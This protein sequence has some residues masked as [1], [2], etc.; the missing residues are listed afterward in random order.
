VLLNAVVIVLRE[1]LEASLIISVFLA[2]SQILNRSLKWMLLALVLG[3]ISGFIYA[4]TIST[5]SMAFGGIGQE[6]VNATINILIFMALVIFVTAVP[7]QNVQRCRRLTV[8]AIMSTVILAIMREG[9]EVLL[10][11]TGFIGV[12]DLLGPVLM[13][14]AVGAGL[15]VSVGVFIYYFIVNLIPRHGVWVG[16]L[17]LL[18]VAGSLMSQAVEFLIQADLL[19][20]SE[21]IWNSSNI[22][23]EH[24]VA[25]Q[26]L[27]ALLGYEATPQTSQVIAYICS[28][29]ALLCVA[30]FS[31]IKRDRN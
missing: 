19:T 31:F 15:G 23:D 28:M 24:S 4:G 25:G 16:Y 26:L 30:M 10:F 20:S 1:V 11:I 8:I 6:I 9:S 27:F 14:G 5:V 22:I 7:H 3:L 29:A 2:L 17:L 12:P 13:G 21:P 18:L